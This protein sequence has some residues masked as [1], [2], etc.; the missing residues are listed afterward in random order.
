[1]KKSW[2]DIEKLVMKILVTEFKVNPRAMRDSELYSE[3]YIGY[4]KACRS[5]NPDKGQFNTY[6][7]MVIRGHLKD[8]LKYNSGIIHIPVA[9]KETET[10]DTFS[11]YEQNDNGIELIEM[12]ESTL[13]FSDDTVL[14]N[15]FI[16]SLDTFIDKEKGTLKTALIGI[17]NNIVSDEKLDNSIHRQFY[18]IARKKLKEKYIRDVKNGII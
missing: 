5:F 7:M 8:Y 3:S 11:L 16:E 18:H 9:K 17:R 2:L 1:M 6:C 12:F 4:D 10:I 13:D 14:R 15:Y